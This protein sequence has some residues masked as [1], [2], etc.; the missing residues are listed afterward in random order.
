[1]IFPRLSRQ[2]KAERF[3]EVIPQ[4]SSILPN[5]LSCKWFPQVFWYLAKQVAAQ[6]A[7]KSQVEKEASKS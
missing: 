5:I 1:M 6:E 7:S 4:S 3:T 2:T